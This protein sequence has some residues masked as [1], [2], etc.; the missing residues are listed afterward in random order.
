MT[1]V[2]ALVENDY[3]DLTLEVSVIGI[4]SDVVHAKKMIQEYYGR[5]AEMKYTH[6]GEFN[7]EGKMYVEDVINGVLHEYHIFLQW[8]VLDEI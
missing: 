6:I 2:L 3:S 7:F 8:F 1:R 4:A 5:D